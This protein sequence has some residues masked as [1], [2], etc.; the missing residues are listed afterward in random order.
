MSKMY[1]VY[2]CEQLFYS[3]TVEAESEQ[4]AIDKAQEEWSNDGWD[5]WGECY[6]SNAEINDAAAHIANCTCEG[7]KKC[8]GISYWAE[9]TP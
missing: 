6:N 1:D 2:M 7:C 9:V 5:M 4:D 8:R 3:V